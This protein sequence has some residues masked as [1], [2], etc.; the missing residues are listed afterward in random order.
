MTATDDQGNVNNVL[1][2]KEHRH[3]LPSASFLASTRAE[4]S[5]ES[6]LENGTPVDDFS[7]AEEAQLQ[8]TDSIS[9]INTEQAADQSSLSFSELQTASTSDLNLAQVV[10]HDLPTPPL[11][12]DGVET[13]S[14]QALSE[15]VEDLIPESKDPIQPSSRV[16]QEITSKASSYGWARIG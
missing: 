7:R 9:D 12:E 13:E 8:L 10:S 2:V 3:P 14:K 4:K 11:S 16:D 15:S 6:S 1:V 5:T